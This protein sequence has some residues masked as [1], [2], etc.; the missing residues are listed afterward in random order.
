MPTSLND[1]Q[2]ARIYK[3]FESF[4]YGLAQ[5]PLNEQRRREQIEVARTILQQHVFAGVSQGLPLQEAMLEYLVIREHEEALHL[6]KTPV[7]DVLVP[8]FLSL[9][10]GELQAVVKRLCFFSSSAAPPPISPDS[11]ILSEEDTKKHFQTLLRESQLRHLMKQLGAATGEK[12]DPRYRE[13]ESTFT[14]YILWKRNHRLYNYIEVRFDLDGTITIQ[15][16]SIPMHE[17]Q[18]NRNALEKALEQAYKHPKLYD[19]RS[20]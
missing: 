5:S 11:D 13:N 10:H 16:I 6:P 15:E 2:Q 17:W 12:F 4:L 19:A 1:T 8:H 20:S 9:S 14:V 18:S 7:P 3:S